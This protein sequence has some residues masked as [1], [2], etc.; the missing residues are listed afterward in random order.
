M[1]ASDAQSQARKRTIVLSAVVAVILVIAGVVLYL[2]RPEVAD[3]TNIEAVAAAESAIERLKE[4][5]PQ[6][7]APEYVDDKPGNVARPAGQ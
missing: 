5:P 6:A 3:E 1:P 7:P 2:Q 4:I